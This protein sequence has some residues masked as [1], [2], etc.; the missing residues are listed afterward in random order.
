KDMRVQTKGEFGGLGIEVTMEN[1]LVKVITPIEDTPASKARVRA[2]DYISQI[3]GEEVRGMT[4]N[5][6]VEKMRGPVDTPIKLTIRAEAPTSRSRSP[7]CVTSSRSRRSST[8]S[9]TTSV[10]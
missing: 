1:E 7:S 5:D 10:T 4:L 8:T 6:A 9:T 2:G 3:D